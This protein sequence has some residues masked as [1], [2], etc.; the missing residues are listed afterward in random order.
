LMPAFFPASMLFSSQA[1]FSPRVRIVCIPSLSCFTSS[2]V[3]P[4]T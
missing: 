3:L 4:C 1:M 2:G